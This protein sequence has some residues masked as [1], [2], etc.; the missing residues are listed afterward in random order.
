MESPQ[1][2]AVPVKAFGSA[3]SR[4][5]AFAAAYDEYHRRALHVAGLLHGNRAEAEDAVAE[6]FAR[7]WR[8][9]RHTDIE[10]LWPYLR[11]SL[12]NDFR[13]GLRR[14]ALERR[15]IERAKTQ[16]VFET[17]GS[18]SKVGPREL[19]VQALRQLPPRQRAAVVLRYFDDLTE[20]QTAEVLGCS[21]GTVKSSV[22]RGLEKL[23]TIL[24]EDFA[25]EE[26]R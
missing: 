2:A 3:A 1:P 5:I 8:R 25:R 6:A 22:F 18:I 11:A 24:G 19:M 12:L 13:S 15:E 10:A 21:V 4:Q 26:I 20:E 9:Y 23:R 7:I 16:G 17:T 14:K